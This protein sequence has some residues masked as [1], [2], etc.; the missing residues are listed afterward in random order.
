MP[1]LGS[2]RT[3]E[4]ARGDFEQRLTGAKSP[5]VVSA[6]IESETRRGRDYVRVSI[7]AAVDAADVA[8][9]LTAAWD[10]FLQAAEDDAGWDMAA[11]SAEVRPEAQLSIM[12]AAAAGVQRSRSGH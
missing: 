10:A 7:M 8:E 5:A 3:W 12:C 1:R 6:E 11:A 4:A 9:A 2:R